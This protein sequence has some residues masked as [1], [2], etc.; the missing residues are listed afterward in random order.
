MQSTPPIAIGHQPHTHRW[1]TDLAGSVDR[2]A[3]WLLAAAIVA[4]IL[5][6]TLLSSL[7]LAL[8]RQGFDMAGNEQTIWNTL[9]GRPFRISAFAMMDYDFDDGPVLLQLPLAALYSLFPSPYTL[10]A[11]QSAALGLAAWPLFLLGRAV[12]P[13]PWQALALALV[14]LLHP[15]TQHT[16]MYEFQLRSFMVPFALAALLFLWRGRLWPFLL[17]LFLMCCTKTEGALTVAM[18]GLYALLLRRPWPFVLLPLALGTSWFLL[19]LTVIVP[20]FS[21][22]DFVTKIYSYGALGSSI[23]EVITTVLTR[24][25]LVLSTISEP[26]KLAFLLRLL[27]LL[28]FLP[29]L[30]LASILALPVLLLNLLAPNLVQWSLNYQYQAL[31]LPFLLV[32]AAQ[33]L[34][35]LAA[36]A[37]RLWGQPWHER[38]PTVGCLALLAGMLVACLTM[39]NVALSLYRN[40]EPPE[41][42]R[43]AQAILA[44][45]PPDAAVAASSFLAPHL[46]QRQQLFFFPGNASYPKEYIDRAEYLVADSAAP[47]AAERELLNDYIGRPNW[48]LVAREG[49]FVL[50]RKQP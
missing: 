20:A 14:F 47:K 32:G 50:L 5:L 9:H 4:Y 2:R 7:K 8:F 37:A 48:Q 34:V 49:A 27:G 36:I 24:P 39:N 38:I 22:G 23:G 19:A 21:R 18:F 1:K 46:A 30:G 13:R 45:V 41:R 17:F 3:G 31:T 10:L 26:P 6:F 33:G 11:L 43:Q 29:L 28:A 15:W 42:V 25:L 35:L 40:H 16:N 12:L 44:L